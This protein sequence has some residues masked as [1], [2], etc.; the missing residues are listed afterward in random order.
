[1]KISVDMD[2]CDVHGQCAFA[3]PDVFQLDDVG[4]LTYDSEPDDSTRA[5]VENAVRL[6]PVQAIRI[7]R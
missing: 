5:N 7:L 4:D 2:V 6:C 1:M 3:A